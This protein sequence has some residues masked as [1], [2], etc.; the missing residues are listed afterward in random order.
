MTPEMA[1]SPT[2]DGASPSTTETTRDLVRRFV[3]NVWNGEDTDAIED[4]TTDGLV[5]HALGAGVDRTREEFAEFHAGLLEAVP[6]LEHAVE[7]VVVE[8][9]RAVAYVSVRGTPERQ[10]GALAPTGESFDAVVFQKYRIEDGRIAEVWV[11]PNA[12]G[13][14]RQLGVLPDS[15]GKVLRLLVGALK[16]RLL[17]R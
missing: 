8:G 5:V 17:G 12:M 14:L 10:Y 13:M 3:T 7:D 11:L 2:R 6:D 15:P 1:H 16:G 9:D 4:L